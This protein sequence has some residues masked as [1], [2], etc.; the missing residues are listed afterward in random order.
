MCVLNLVKDFLEDC[1]HFGIVL[2]QL[3]FTGLFLDFIQVS[4]QIDGGIN[5][6]TKEERL[7]QAKIAEQ[8]ERYDDMSREMKAIVQNDGK[9]LTDEERNLLSVAYK[10]VVGTRRSAWRV[11]SF[12]EQKTVD[13]NEDPV[14]QKLSKVYREI[15]EKELNDICDEVIQ[16]LDNNLISADDSNESE[17]FYQKMKGDYFRYKVE[18][19][20]LGLRDEYAESSR[21]AYEKASQK[22]KE[23]MLPTNPIRLGLALNYS[24]FYYEIKND[25]NKACELAKGAFDEAIESLETSSEDAM[26]DSMLIMQLLR[27]NL[28]LWSSEN[29]MCGE[30]QDE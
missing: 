19:A 20:L 8:I 29:E 27:D 22:A 15:I 23:S 9:P 10:N 26:K 11:I 1:G 28:T 17:V 7:L 5:M 14:K 25:S 16:L 3:D 6:S 21:S 12:L 18:I 2:K 4:T 24:V 13:K 30:G